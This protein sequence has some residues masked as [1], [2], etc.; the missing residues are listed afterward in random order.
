[1]LPL[2]ILIT[3]GIILVTAP[4]HAALYRPG[5][6]LVKFKPLSHP[7]QG[8]YASLDHARPYA[9]GVDDTAAA[10]V[11]LKGRS[12][13]VYAEPNYIITAESIP[14]DWGYNPSDWTEV[15]LPSAWDYV[16]NQTSLQTVRIAVLDSGAD[17]DHPELTAVLIPGYNFINHTADTED[18]TGHG[19]RICGIIGAKGNNNAG[20]AGVAWDVPLEIMPVRIMQSGGEITIGTVADAV[21]GIY[22]AVDHGARIINA[23][24]GFDTYSSALKDAIGYALDH[25]VLFVCS[26]GNQDDDNDVLAHYPSNYNLDNIIAVAAMTRYGELA[27]FSNY[28]SYGVHI[29]A[30]G[31]GLKSTDLDGKIRLWTDGTSYAAGFVS[32]VAAMVLADN[33]ALTVRELRERI[34]QGS[35]ISDAFSQDL[36]DS[37]GCVNAYNAV[38]GIKLHA[39]KDTHDWTPPSDD[40]QD[41]ANSVGKGGTCLIETAAGPGNALAYGIIALVLILMACPRGCCGSS[42]RS[43]FHRWM[44]P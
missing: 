2:E 4:L 1:M 32:G 19:T 33:P 42:T 9:V 41:A 44:R 28:G 27:S 18:D 21:D 40:T 38:L 26:A 36:N 7:G 10:V 12:D 30:P 6:I 3:C 20:M 24:W 13:I 14:D 39:L 37:G 35:I 16:E 17:S 34:L 15:D 29:A 22:Y 8:L 11:E 5:E 31:T 43:Y 25:E 23:S